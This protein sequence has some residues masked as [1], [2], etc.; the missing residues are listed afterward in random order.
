MFKMAICDQSAEQAE[1]LA[2][3]VRACLTHGGNASLAV[4]YFPTLAELKKATGKES[5]KYRL[6]VMDTTVQGED[7]I[8]AA[9]QL[10]KA[11]IAA[12]IVFYTED[13]S[14]ALEAYSA[15]P[16]GYILKPCASSEL[17]DLISFV[18]ER[19]ARKPSIILKGVDGRKNGFRVDDIIYI[20]VFRTELE[21]HTAEG[22]TVCV[23]SL[24][25]A[26]EKLPESRFYRSHRSFIVNLGRIKRIERYQFTMDNGDVVAVAK[27]RYAEA[28][29]AWR[30]YCG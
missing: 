8:E 18:A 17:S 9:R 13:A 26:C 15:Y 22:K 4:E 24:R 29:Q 23:G 14:R 7:G 12:D 5:G 21:V 16:T 28:K 27:N 19:G 20:E 11:G 30:T 25:E 6:I 1:Q 10:R 3:A 2:K